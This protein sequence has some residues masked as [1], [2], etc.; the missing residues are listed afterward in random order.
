M[1]RYQWQQNCRRC[2]AIG[3]WE[4]SALFAFIV[5]VGWSSSS[6]E[7]GF[8]LTHSEKQIPP[9]STSQPSDRALATDDPIIV[10]TKALIARSGRAP[11]DVAS[12]AQGVVHWQ[13]PAAS[14]EAAARG[15]AAADHDEIESFN[16]GVFESARRFPAGHASR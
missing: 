16:H 14:L 6:G 5:I 8:L 3:D 1:A 12:L 4:R 13:P 9:L 7:V 2:V 15:A 11:S 10:A